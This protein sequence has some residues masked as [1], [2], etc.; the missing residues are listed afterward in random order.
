MRKG[1]RRMALLMA[2]LMV[3]GSALAGESKPKTVFRALYGAIAEDQREG[4]LYFSDPHMAEVPGWEADFEEHMRKLGRYADDTEMGLVLCSGD[5]IGSLDTNEEAAEKLSYITDFN[6]N[7]FGS[8]R[9]HSAVGNHDTNELGSLDTPQRQQ[10]TTR[11][12]VGAYTSAMMPQTGTAYY[13]F[14]GENTRFYLLDSGYEG[15]NMNQNGGGS[16]RWGMLEWLARDLKENDPP[17]AAILTHI[18]YRTSRNR[19]AGQLGNYMLSLAAA[20]NRHSVFKADGHTFDFRGCTGRLEFVL[21]GH[22]HIDYYAYYNGIPVIT[23]RNALA[24][25]PDG[26]TV[27]TFDLV[28]VDYAERLITFVRAG[29]GETRTIALDQ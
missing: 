8:L 11:L 27:L 22:I 1:L 5:W 16:Y 23:T 18:Y 14:N 9:Y 19:S 6:L 17:H 15:Q 7:L 21:C 24:A 4:F 10:R 29:E 20:Y 25:Q 13:A 26:S 12:S 28:A 2:L 3:Q